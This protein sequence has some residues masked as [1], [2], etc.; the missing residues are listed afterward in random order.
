MRDC[1]QREDVKTEDNAD[2]IYTA[3]ADRAA[4]TTNLP[5]VLCPE[6]SGCYVF[7]RRESPLVSR[8]LISP[9]RMSSILSLK[10]SS[11]S[12]WRTVLVSPSS[13]GKWFRILDPRWCNLLHRKLKPT[14]HGLHAFNTLCYI[15]GCGSRTRRPRPEERDSG[16]VSGWLET[17]VSRFDTGILSWELGDEFIGVRRRG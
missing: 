11:R 14:L 17:G 9:C 16:F 4:G 3:L 5:F 2:S 13:T 12:S 8:R 6:D 15:G 1:F 10:D 7:S